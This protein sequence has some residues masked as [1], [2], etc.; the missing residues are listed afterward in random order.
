MPTGEN[1]GGGAMTQPN[2]EG[3]LQ[4]ILS[5]GDVELV[6]KLRRGATWSHG[7]PIGAT[8]GAVNDPVMAEAADRILALNAEKAA[9]SSRCGMLEGAAQRVLDGLNRRI[10]AAPSDCV[11]VFDG[12]ADLHAALSAD[13]E[14]L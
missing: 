12:I 9:L 10:D 2:D 1:M 7:E 5:G 6:E 4:P 13:G 8:V 3:L 11:P 14:K